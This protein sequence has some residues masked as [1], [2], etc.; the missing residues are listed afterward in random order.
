MRPYA[1][2][3]ANNIQWVM[4]REV[5]HLCLLSLEPP[6]YWCIM[7]PMTFQTQSYLV[8]PFLK[9]ENKW[10]CVS[11]LAVFPPQL[12]F[13]TI[14]SAQS[15]NKENRIYTE[16]LLL[17]LSWIRCVFRLTGA[18]T[19]RLQVECCIKTFSRET[20]IILSNVFK[21]AGE[22][23]P[24]FSLLNNILTVTEDASLTNRESSF[25]GSVQI[26]RKHGAVIKR[27]GWIH[28]MFHL[29]R[30]RG[31]SSAGCSK[32]ISSICVNW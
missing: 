19:A 6:H 30:G 14:L 5:T 32:V 25:K 12:S 9:L 17:L 24:S 7:K 1:R 15:V 10:V 29:M 26:K 23:S 28:R 16:C 18:V 13:L 11:Y 8:C 4:V 27:S 2:P 31:C 3:K 22:V 20:W 21:E